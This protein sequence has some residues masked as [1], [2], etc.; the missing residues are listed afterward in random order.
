[1]AELQEKDKAAEDL[2][3]AYNKFVGKLLE[4]FEPPKTFKELEKLYIKLHDYLKTILNDLDLID[5]NWAELSEQK[6][7]ELSET[8]GFELEYDVPTILKW[9]DDSLNHCRESIL[10]AKIELEEIESGIVEKI[11]VENN[12][13][14]E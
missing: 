2:F 5:T 13:D 6:K 9:V 8:Y 3:N 4:G 10:L 7:K 11:R 1:M 14:I 12:I